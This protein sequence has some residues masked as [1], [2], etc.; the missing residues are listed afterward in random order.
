MATDA[1]LNIETIVQRYL[2][3]YK[4]TTEDYSTYLEHACNCYRDFRLYDSNQVVTSKVTVNAN[5]WIDMPNDMMTFVDL[6]VPIEGEFWSFTEKQYIVNT[7]TFTGLVEGR[8]STVGEGAE[9]A[10]PRTTGYAAAGGINDY[11]YVLDWEA[12]RIYIDGVSNATVVLMYVSSGIETSGVT[13]VPE[14]LTPLFDSYLLWKS[15]YW[16][17]DLVRERGALEKDYHNTRLSLRNLIWGMSYPQWRDL[18]L[19]TFRQAPSR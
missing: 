6:C 1:L 2:V 12:R 14:M 3:K 19:S 11:N 15:S 10:T 5:K 8:D 9:I 18:L 17:P 7:T 16:L 4:K 13:Q